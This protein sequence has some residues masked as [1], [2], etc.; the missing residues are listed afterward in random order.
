MK[1]FSF[2]FIIFLASATLS[3]CIASPEMPLATPT[4]G[5]TPNRYQQ[6]EEN[7]SHVAD[8]APFTLL[9]PARSQL[10]FDIEPI[11]VDVTPVG[12]TQPFVVVQSY[13]GLGGVIRITQ[14]SQVG[15]I[16][17]QSDATAPVRG[18]LGYWVELDIGGRVLYWEEN[19][20]SMTIG[21]GLTRDDVLILAEAL[22]PHDTEKEEAQQG[23]P[24]HPEAYRLV[25]RLRAQGLDVQFVDD[26]PPTAMLAPAPGAG[27][28]L[29]DG[30]L[31]VHWYPNPEAASQKVDE[32]TGDPRWAVSEWVDL[33]FYRCDVVIALYVSTDSGALAAL[34]DE[35]GAPFAPVDRSSLPPVAP[36][37]SLPVCEPARFPAPD[38][39]W[40][41][42]LDLES[43]SLELE[44]PDGV[45]HTVFPAGS[46]ASDASWS[47]DSSRLAV[48]VREAAGEAQS[49]GAISSAEVWKIEVAESGL[50]EPRPIHA[51]D[52]SDEDAGPLIALGAWSPEGS[53]LLFWVGPLSAS[54]QADGLPLWS[55]EVETGR[56]T[57][58]AETTLLNTAY[59]SWAPDGSTL[60]FTDGGYRSAQVGKWLS[61]YEVASGQVRTYIP[62]DELIPGQ[63]A[64]SPAGDTIAFAATDAGQTGNEWVD[65]MSWEN[66]AVLARRI[67]LLDPQSGEYR[68]LN[69]TDAYQD[70]PR[71]DADGETLYYV[72]MDGDKAILMAVDPAS[73]EVQ[74]LP[75]CSAPLPSEAGYYGQVDWT[76]LY[77]QCPT[78]FESLSPA[79][80]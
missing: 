5:A 60:V 47:P 7:L 50:S 9:V 75:D 39:G 3:A 2:S 13:R 19:D 22:T 57:R 71:W 1:R 46:M 74:P 66:P 49:L 65:W 73:G 40:E 11:G 34:H 38:G 63:V 32:L 62:E 6:F 4:Q 14:T 70:A 25:E 35:C 53:R 44:G 80:P 17:A 16:P 10:P 31:H 18:V 51:P 78:V 54:I 52:A 76:S 15:Q 43:G 24:I 29:G 37:P 26:I 59:Q 28:R 68:R 67:F 64:W 23:R 58:L 79:F 41:A 48:A 61:V 56:T 8:Q 27:Y 12:K 77:V 69:A 20:T 45:R 55:L 30:W 42:I 36:T 33:H 21:G 72:Q